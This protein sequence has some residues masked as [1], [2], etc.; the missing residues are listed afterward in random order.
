MLLSHLVG[1]KLLFDEALDF[2]RNVKYE[3]QDPEMGIGPTN[4][5]QIEMSLHAITPAAMV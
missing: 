2:T 1:S 4:M 3:R 5:M